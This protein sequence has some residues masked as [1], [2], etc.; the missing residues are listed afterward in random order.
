MASVAGGTRITGGSLRGERVLVLPGASVRPVRARVRAAL[1]SILGAELVGAR[2]L[3]LYAG[4][5]A[6]G[7]EAISRGAGYVLF[8][9][10]D[11][12]ALALLEENRRRLGLLAQSAIAA[13]DLARATPPAET[14]FD[15]LLADPPFADYAAGA[16]DVI[17]RVAAACL[18]PG[19][20]LALETP[21][22]AAPSPST[23]IEWEAPRPWGNTELRLGRR[24]Q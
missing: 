11:R 16:W 9:E 23:A 20:R 5:G 12:R 24:R 4:S 8:V 18:R 22:G 13:L 3:D 19:G 7:I 1:F 6:L 21:R 10:R 15:I 2:A 14:P 17:E